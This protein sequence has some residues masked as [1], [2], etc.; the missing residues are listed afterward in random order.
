MASTTPDERSEE[1][2]IQEALKNLDDEYS[3]LEA[4]EELL[5]DG[6]N[7]LKEDESCLQNALMETSSDVRP[8][9]AK[10]RNTDAE[11]VL[12]LEQALMESSS[13]EED[14]DDD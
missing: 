7:K 5:K 13:E 14:D 12:R 4:Q 8:V 2:K 11:A 10:R 3:L 6:L 9:S 1:S